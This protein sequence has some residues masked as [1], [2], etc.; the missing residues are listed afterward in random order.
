[1]I[2]LEKG[3]VLC[4]AGNALEY[5]DKTGLGEAM[6]KVMLRDRFF[7]RVKSKEMIILD[8]TSR[9]LPDRELNREAHLK[10]A[11]EAGAGI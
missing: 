4:V 1:M 8:A 5:F 10:R 11:F 2:Q 7:D 3:L 9:E 6:E